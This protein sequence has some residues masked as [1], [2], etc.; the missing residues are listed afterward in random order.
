MRTEGR[1]FQVNVEGHCLK[2]LFSVGST[3]TAAT[4]GAATKADE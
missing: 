2:A 3:P 1:S 4:E